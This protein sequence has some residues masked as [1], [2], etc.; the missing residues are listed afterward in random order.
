MQ[1]V[2]RLAERSGSEYIVHGKFGPLGKGADVVTKRKYGPDH[3]DG[4]SC[5]RSQ[6]SYHS[7]RYRIDCFRLVENQRVYDRQQQEWVD[8]EPVGYDVAIRQERLGRHA[9]N[10]LHRGDRVTVSGVYQ[11][12]PYVHKRTGEPGLNRRIA[13]CDVSISMFDDR[14]DQPRA[15]RGNRSA[16]RSFG[17]C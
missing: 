4:Q 17:S 9:L 10:A 8:G 12:S 3:C 2:S 14:F 16:D 7:G 15:D 5:G 11:V 13:A 1:C 6:R